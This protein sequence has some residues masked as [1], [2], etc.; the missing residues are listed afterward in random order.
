MSRPR[1]SSPALISTTYGKVLSWWRPLMLLLSEY[2]FMPT[3]STAQILVIADVITGVCQLTRSAGGRRAT[4]STSI[5]TKS[6]SARMPQSSKMPFH[7]FFFFFL[8][9]KGQVLVVTTKDRK[10][11]NTREVD[12]GTLKIL[13][14]C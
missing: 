7:L 14:S 13:R 1:E 5:W 3:K 8:F 11:R 9:Q 6:F 2:C 4:P 10:Q 12:C